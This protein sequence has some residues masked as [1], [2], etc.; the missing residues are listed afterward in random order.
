[1]TD[2]RHQ[3]ASEPA[4]IRITVVIQNRYVLETDEATSRE[5]KKRAGIPVDCSLHW[6]VQAG[7]EAIPDD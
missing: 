4:N 1:M 6:R 5:L 3:V 7:T 2:S